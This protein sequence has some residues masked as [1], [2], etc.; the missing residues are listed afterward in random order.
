MG[1]CYV[2][3]P[4]TIDALKDYIREAIGEIQLHTIDNVL[5]NL[6]DRLGY[7]MTSQGSHLSEIIFLF[8]LCFWKIALSAPELM[9][10]GAV[11]CRQR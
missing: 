9:S 6:T 10:L 1:K 5:K 3:K 11:G 7:C 4:E 2:D 8:A